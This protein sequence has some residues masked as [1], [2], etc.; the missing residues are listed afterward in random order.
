MVELLLSPSMS[1]FPNELWLEICTYLPLEALR[2]LS[3]THR[4][5]YALARVL[6]FTEFKLYPYPYYYK[7]PQALLEAALERLEFWFSPKV[8]PHVRSC[9]ARYNMSRWQ[10][11]LL[12]S[13]DRVPHVLMNSF[14]ERLP[15]FTGLK[16]LNTDQIQWTQLGIVNLC[17]LSALTHLELSRSQMAFGERIDPSSLTL[18]ISTFI[19]NC[20]FSM[21]VVWLSLLSRDTLRELSLSYPHALARPGVLPFPHVH[22]L[23]VNEFPIRTEGTHA[24]CTKFPTLRVLV[25][26]YRGVLHIPLAQMSEIFPVLERYTGSHRNLHIFTHRTTL[27]HIT[28]DSG[29]Q[30]SNVLTEFQGVVSLPNITSLTASFTSA[31]PSEASENSFGEGEIDA[32][33]TLFP[34]LTV[35]E[36]KLMPD[37]DEDVLSTPHSRPLSSGCSP[38]TPS[39]QT[40]YNPC[41]SSGTYPL[42][43]TAAI[44][45]TG[46]N[47]PP[48]TP[49]TSLTSPPCSRRSSNVVRG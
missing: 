4:A 44:P 8:A 24:M 21:H 6:G 32:L 34:R 1:R 13:H 30:F 37:A 42:C 18:R 2:N 33:F 46:T 23:S 7:P 29:F 3:S 25:S 19:T 12:M 15:K 47:P 39:S 49:P 48:L 45:R 38:F 16:R 36:L 28:L 26:D 9:T 35:L 14:F 5:L 17:A 22:K 11:S 31:A 27:T 10:G 43:T 40:H 41:R 20:D